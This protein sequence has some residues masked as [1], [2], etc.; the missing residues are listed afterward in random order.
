[1]SIILT[2]NAGSVNTRLAAFDAATLASKGHTVSHNAAEAAEW[3]SSAGTEGVVAIGHRVVH[4]GLE[5]TEPTVITDAVL[6]K[7]KA[8]IPLAPL[9]QPAA[10]KLIEQARVLYPR[11]PHIACFDTAFHHTI[12]EIERRFPLPGKFYE[13]GIV[14]YGFHG[15]SY[16][17]VADVLRDFPGKTARGRVIAAHLGGGSSACAMKDLQSVDCTTG[18][19]TLD[20]L[21]MGT[22]C[23]AL[24]PGVL[25]Y[26]LTEKHMSVPQV[27]D[28]L[29]HDS[30]LKGVSGIS[31]D[32]KELMESK[33]PAAH[34][35]VEL[36][37]NLA[38]KEIAALLP[39][40]G[41]LDALVF[42]GGIGE[43][44]APVREKIIDLLHWIGKFEVYVIPTNEEIVIAKACQ[45]LSDQRI[46]RD[47]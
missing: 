3:L 19:S 39:A 36:Y 21:M 9:H 14:R 33:S 27:S 16:Q 22:R 23:G 44:A 45:Q 20:G 8:L 15:L 34:E 25:L 47:Y 17:H 10:L 11:V 1:M 6:A 26:L 7:L 28:L 37:C 24:D 18:F 41:G 46:G 12:P 35:A 30:G 4:G 29:Y 5:F 43:N 2:C 32:M 38:A 13:E 42:T 31:E 40:L